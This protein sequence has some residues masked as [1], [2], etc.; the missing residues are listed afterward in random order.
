MSEKKNKSERSTMLIPIYDLQSQV[1]FLYTLCDDFKFEYE[2]LLS[3]I[4]ADWICKFQQSCQV[5]SPFKAF[6]SFLNTTQ[7]TKDFLLQVK[8]EVMKNESKSES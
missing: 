6:L 1:S 3:L 5:T 4:I 2:S 8:K 7:D